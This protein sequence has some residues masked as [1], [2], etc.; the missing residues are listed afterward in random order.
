MNLRQMNSILI[1]GFFAVL[2]GFVNAQTITANTRLDVIGT[3]VH[4]YAEAVFDPAALNLYYYNQAEIESAILSYNNYLNN[5]STILTLDDGR[6]VGAWQAS[7]YVPYDKNTSYRFKARIGI[8]FQSKRVDSAGGIPVTYYKD[9]ALFSKY[10]LNGG[11]GGGS[12][13]GTHAWIGSPKADME[14]DLQYWGRETTSNCVELGEVFKD[15]VPI[16]VSVSPNSVDIGASQSQQ[17][18]WSVFGG[19]SDASRDVIWS[20]YPNVGSISSTGLYTAPSGPISAP[21][22][23]TI[24]ATSVADSSKSGAADLTL[25]PARVVVNPSLVSLLAGGNQSFTSNVYFA[26]ITT[27]TW[28]TTGGTVDTTGFY[29]AP[30]ALGV[31]DVIATSVFDTNRSAIAKV[32]VVPPVTISVTAYPGGLISPQGNVVIPQGTDKTFSIT[33]NAGYVIKSLYVNGVEVAPGG[34]YVCTYTFYNVQSDQCIHALFIPEY[35]ISATSGPGGQIVPGSVKIPQ[36]GSQSFTGVPTPPYMSDGMAVDGVK[37]INSSYTFINVQ[38]PHSI[39]AEFYLP[40][41]KVS[42]SARVWTADINGDGRSDLISIQNGGIVYTALS[43]GSGTPGWTWNSGVRMVNDNAQIWFA[44]VNGDGKAD[45][46]CVQNGGIVYVSLS[47]GTGF[48]GWSWS[49]NIRMVADNARIWIAD[50]NG[51]GKS[52]LVCVQNGGIVYVSTSL[53]VGAP[54]WTWSSGSRMVNDNARIWLADVN[55]DK[56]ADLVCIQNGGIAYVAL[57]LGVGAPA[58]SWNSGVRLVNDT[59]QI[60]LKDVNGDGKADMVCVQNGGIVYTGLSDGKGFAGWSWNSGTRMVND[61]ATI[62]FADINGDGKADL[63]C[64]QNGGI[65]YVAQSDGKGYTGWSWNSGTRMVN[66]PSA[67]TIVWLDD[68]NGDGKS[69]LFCVQNGGIVYIANPLCSGAPVWSWASH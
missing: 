14:T 69:D 16:S 25:N 32:R 28:S 17:F 3:Q 62:L 48:N 6:K 27:T 13:D 2:A 66:D 9:I 40:A 58:W 7:G 56:K 33:A 47:D 65:V 44:D 29:T 26:P 50:V 54:A 46:V 64:V 53:G 59:A 36:G 15:L 57:T 30:N 39:S 43:N 23:L 35:L 21:V 38:R 24:K 67:T 51:D 18:Y 34:P 10:G 63:F 37:Y 45:L 11:G 41:R 49:S 12:Y 1:I 42:D 55:G 5:F 61:N 19:P 22:S 68:V 4:A 8:W 20:I 31:Y 52:D 60:W